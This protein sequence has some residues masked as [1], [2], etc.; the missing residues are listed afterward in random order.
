MWPELEDVRRLRKGL[1][2]TQTALAAKAGVSQSAIVKVERGQMNPSYDLVRRLFEALEAERRT[3]ESRATADDVKSRTVRWVEA[4]DTLDAVA[5]AMKRY[6]FSQMPVM[7]GKRAVGSVTDGTIN[8]LIL[9]GKT[10]ADLARIPV[11]EAMGPPFPQVD[12]RAPIDVAAA[13]LRVYDAVLV[14]TR[15]EVSGI[16]TKSDLMKLL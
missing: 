14:T 10:P 2:M 1:G 11:A 16:V 8:D 6:G 9:S 7:E 5:R 12:G 15:G 3:R 4:A 13:M